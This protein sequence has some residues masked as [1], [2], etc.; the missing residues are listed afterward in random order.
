MTKTIATLSNTMEILNHYGLKA[1]KKYGQNFLVDANITDKIARL[2]TDEKHPTIEIGPGIGCL[3]QM[4]CKYSKQ[5]YAYEIDPKLIPVLKANFADLDN[6]ELIFGDFLQ[7]DLDSVPYKDE[8]INVCAN[9]PYYVTTPILFKLF[10][11]SLNI[12]K[13][14]VMVQKE[15]ADR[16]KAKVNDED[17]NALSVIVNYLY[18]VKVVTQVPAS[19]FFP[20]PRVDST[21]I[22]FT[23]KVKRDPDFEKAFFKLVKMAFT[24]RRKTLWNNLKQGYSTQELTTLF[25]KLE[26]NPNLRGQEMELADFM[27]IYEVLNER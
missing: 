18:D 3:T 23:P 22:S 2:S 7:V 1:Q 6:F 5:V 10:E 27:R 26:L 24:Q 14:S 12:L 13:I 4:L 11:S 21:V 20:R 17:Y 16:F 15:V 8:A 19:V 9:L 25:E